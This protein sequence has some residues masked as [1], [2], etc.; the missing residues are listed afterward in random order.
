[1][2]QDVLNKENETKL[3]QPIDK[4]MPPK[5]D[6]KKKSEKDE[7]TSENIK[8]LL[9]PNKFEGDS[10]LDLKIDSQPIGEKKDAMEADSVIN[11]KAQQVESISNQVDSKLESPV[12][13]APK[14]DRKENSS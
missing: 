14:M 3:N 13:E 10:N 7:L 4:D 12:L 8:T 2:G 11:T 6:V 5:E 9:L 1:M